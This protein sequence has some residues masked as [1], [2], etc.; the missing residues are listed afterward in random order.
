MDPSHV[1]GGGAMKANGLS[2][3]LILCVLSSVFAVQLQAVPGDEHWARTFGGPGPSNIVYALEVQGDRVYASGA[4]SAGPVS[5]N[6]WVEV[7]DGSGWSA[8]PGTFT[9]T[10]PILD[11]LSVRDHLYVC[12][13]F[14]RVDGVRMAGLARWDG[15]SWSGIGDVAGLGIVMATDGVNL[16]LGG[17]FTSVGGVPATNIAKWNPA[18]AGWSALGDSLG[19]DSAGLS[20]HVSALHWTDGVLYAGGAFTNSGS[21]A[22]R[23]LA[24]WDGSNWTEVGGGTDGPVYT[25]AFSDADLYVGGNFT[26]AGATVARGVARW[27]GASWSPL[28]SGLIAPPP[29]TGVAFPTPVSAIAVLGSDLIVGG[30]FT[31]AGGIRALRIA[32]WDGA[33]WHSMGNMNDM[34]V[35]IRTSGTNAYI[36][37][38]FTQADDY[39]VNHLTRWDGTRFHPLGPAGQSE[40]ALFPGLRALASGNGRIY[41]GG[42]L[43]TGIGRIKASRIAAWDGTTWW[44]L[45]SGVRGTNEGSGSSVDAIAVADNG[46]VY[47]GGSFT[48]AGGVSARNIARWDGNNWFPL[49]SGIPGPVNA[50]AVRG[51]E[52]FVGGE[53]TMSTAGG[54]AFNIARWD[55]TTWRNMGGCCMA[56]TIGNFFVNAIAIQ[57]SDVYVGGSFNLSILG[58]GTSHNF[59]KHD[60][61]G[62]VSVGGGVNNRVNSIL[63]LGADIYIGGRFT[64]AGGVPVS[65]IA[66]WDGSTWSNVGGGVLGSGTTFSVSALAAI[67]SDVYAGGSFTNAGGVVTNR[68]AKW[69]GSSWSG[70]GSGV[71]RSFA[72]P[73]VLAMAASGSDLYVGGNFEGAGNKPSFYI[74]RWNETID[75]DFVP[76]LRLSEPMF[77]PYGSFRLSIS[78]AGVPSYVVEASGDLSNWISIHTNTATSATVDD[79]GAIG[80]LQRYYRARS[81]P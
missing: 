46:D 56:G 66:K 80:L 23:N 30:T 53:F 7:W 68:I 36:G 31:N 57:G 14:Q 33:A 6:N 16:Y 75:F 17:S 38:W 1:I 18:T 43:F 70:L 79:P 11:A 2:K 5:T 15:R 55:G 3:S 34:V 32:R 59:A 52:V 47:A 27:D 28:G 22:I 42:A 29:S 54:T 12:G 20:T 72:N 45:G 63:I 71:T 49:G 51:S 76:F 77:D 44:P 37:G 35:K 48:N 69:N 58:G 61:V 9:G 25:F 60:G 73:S 24:R 10:M 50:I 4:W 81:G 19:I 41:A 78:A 65:R 62:W 64:S 21:Q 26:N 67:G 8:L 13:L 40:G 74:A 39:I